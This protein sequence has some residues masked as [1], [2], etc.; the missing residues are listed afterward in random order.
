MGNTKAT[1]WTFAQVPIWLLCNEGISDGAKTLFAYLKYRQGTDAACWPSKQ[2]IADDLGVSTETVGRRLGELDAHGYVV[3][4]TRRGRS[5]LYE[6]L[7]EPEG[8][9]ER[10]EAK[11][12][13]R[14]EKSNPLSKMT[15]VKN[16][17]PLPPKSDTPPPLK[18]DPH[19]DTHKRESITE[20]FAAGAATPSEPSPTPPPKEP[21][22][23]TPAQ[24]MFNALA[25]LCQYD[26]ALLSGKDRG[27]L[28]RVGKQLRDNG[29]TPKHLAQ[30][31]RYWYAADWRGQK[32]Q[33]P[34]PHDVPS[35][36]GRAKEWLENG[37]NNA[38][39]DER[40]AEPI[41]ASQATKRQIEDQ[42]TA[43]AV[44]ALAERAAA[45]APV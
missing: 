13:V 15:H 42:Q 11:V 30:F 16:D 35:N 36:W 17:V 25:D 24:E 44:R 27:I 40:R 7:A 34:T 8:E 29:K 38:R 5:T 33:A 41:D 39:R 45:G 1:G 31:A 6:M 2:T 9:K 12:E 4:H 3:R 23:P 20:N 37:G 18:N 43:Y 32:G 26:L 19:D 28:N 21:K 10:W 22:P 14:K